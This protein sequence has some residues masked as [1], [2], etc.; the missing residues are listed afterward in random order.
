MLAVS[1]TLP[2]LEANRPP[3]ILVHGAASSAAI[4][5]FWQQ[6][7]ATHGWSSYA[8]DLRGH[9]RSHRLDLS[10]TSM[11]DYAADVRILASQFAQPPIVLGWSMGGLVAMMVAA[12]GLVAGCIGLAPST[13]ARHINTTIALRVG[14]F[15]PEEYGITSR[16]PAHQPAMPDL[17]HEERLIALASLGRES[18]FARDERQRGVVIESL[19]CPLLI[20]TG[21]NDKQWPQERYTDLWL[22]A[23]YLTADD[24][25]HW[26]LVL[27]RRVLATI[28]PAVLQWIER[29]VSHHKAC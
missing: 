27:N 10:H 23:D 8:L 19:P 25:S 11:Q 28:I 5:T 26:G 12:S 18:R 16:D 17:D 1:A 9:G 3:I 6:G 20:M 21:T 29:T 15:G 2:H 4:W 24:A 14:E 7:L 13:P 22:A